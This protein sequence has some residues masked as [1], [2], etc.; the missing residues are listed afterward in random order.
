VA[1]S[2]PH[3]NIQRLIQAF[4]LDARRTPASDV[5]LVLVGHAGRAQAAIEAAASM[6]PHLRAL[7]WVDDA[8]LASLYRRA[9]ALAFPSL[10][11]GFGL[12]LVEA[13]A[14]GT[15]V[16]TSGFGAMAAAGDSEAATMCRLDG[17]RVTPRR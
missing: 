8:L 7:G 13:L 6:R 14:L 10:Y 15:P 2:Y 12:P 3:K 1:G 5:G 16:V 4:P 17:T 11:E 9:V